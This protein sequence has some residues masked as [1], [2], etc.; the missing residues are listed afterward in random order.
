MR[1]KITV[2]GTALTFLIAGLIA[3]CARRPGWPD[4]F[5]RT[6]D[7]AG[8]WK[9]IE[10]RE[11]LSKDDLWR[12]VVDSIAQKFDLEV[13]EKDSGYLRTSWKYTAVRGH[14]TPMYRSRIVL[15]IP[16]GSREIVQVKCESN[17]TQGYGWIVGYD[18][19]VLE[20]V[21]GD[22]QGRVGRVRR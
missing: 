16:G 11:D 4:T 2:L 10:V 13:V 1:W 6:L 20:D 8:V 9:T 3:G 14:I 19:R 5:Q 21:Y 15:K 12:S 18:T 7:E 22:I 17:W